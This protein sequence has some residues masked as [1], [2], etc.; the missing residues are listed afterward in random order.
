MR[1]ILSPAKALDY[2][3]PLPPLNGLASGMPAHLDQS[4]R[5]I[6]RLR[7]YT[8]PALA[9][10]MGLSDA[11][12]ALNTAR[13]AEWSADKDDPQA[14]CAVFAFNGD[15][16]DG[17]DARH[18]ETPAL[19]WLE[20][21]LR[22][23]SGLY[24]VLR[25]L[26]RIRAH[27]LEMGTRLPVADSRDLYGFWRQTVTQAL[28]DWLDTDPEGGVLVNLASQEYFKVIDRRTLKP[29]R[30]IEPVFEDWK[31]ERYRVISFYAKKARGLMTRYAAINRLERADDLMQFDEGGYAFVPDA[32]SDTRWVFRRRQALFQ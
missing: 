20:G 3:S 23:L 18:M 29:A 4:T 13:H 28:R 32:S 16:Y 31:N 5:L 9:Q 27:R 22:I 19:A 8:P 17:L 26:D 24:G 11:L 12:A 6:E 10:L 2:T 1:I 25:P 15:V 30:L 14:R 7:E 21:H